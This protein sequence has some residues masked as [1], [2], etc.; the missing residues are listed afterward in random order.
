MQIGKSTINNLPSSNKNVIELQDE[1]QKISGKDPDFHHRDLYDAIDRG[2]YPE[3]DL[4]VQI[5][6]EQDEF[7]FGFDL[8][9]PTKIV[10]ESLVPVTR[11]GKL[12]LNRNVDNFFSETEQI[13]YHPGH[14][15]RG[16]YSFIFF[17]KIASG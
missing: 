14:I 9:D 2:D 7:Q 13:T 15:V 10:P 12:V 6:P 5:I 1:A 11:L 4:C 16:K 17:L 8:L 3:Y